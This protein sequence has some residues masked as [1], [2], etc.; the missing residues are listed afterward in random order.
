MKELETKRL[1]L[2]TYEKRDFDV[3][4]EIWIDYMSTHKEIEKKDLLLIDS[5]IADFSSKDYSW[6]AEEKKSGEPIGNINVIKISKKHKICELAYA[7]RSNARRNGYAT[8]MLSSVIDYLLYEEGFH[9][10]EASYYSGNINSGKVMEKAGMQKEAV[11]I[12]RKYNF[13]TNQYENLIY[14]YAISNK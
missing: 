10:V 7:V 13:K 8:E 1:K 9:V 11:H 14:Y 12:D 6:V 3:L 4:K 5:W 2:R